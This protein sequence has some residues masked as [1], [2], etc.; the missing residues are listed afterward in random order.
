MEEEQG[1]I[2]QQK[3]SHG[4]SRNWTL[5]FKVTDQYL[6]HWAIR[7]YWF[8]GHH[9]SIILN[10]QLAV[11]AVTDESHCTLCK[12]PN[13]TF[14]KHASVLYEPG[15]S[16]LSFF[17]QQWPKKRPFFLTLRKKWSATAIPHK[18]DASKS[19]INLKKIIHWSPHNNSSHVPGWKILS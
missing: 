12:R 7:A 13:R 11:N 3:K 4:G 1:S 10:L 14:T 17:L 15:A 8:Q 9:S 5:N 6:S 19:G 16:K 2:F 18:I